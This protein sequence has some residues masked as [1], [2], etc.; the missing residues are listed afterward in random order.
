MADYAVWE[1]A[2]DRLRERCGHDLDFST[3]LVLLSRSFLEQPLKGQEKKSRKAFQV[4]YH[5]CSECAKAWMQT[6]D[7]IEGMPRSLVESREI[8]AE[9]HVLDEGDSPVNR[10]PP[11]PGGS[12][13]P[14]GPGGA[15]SPVVP[16]EERDIPN[17]PGIRRHVLNRD[18]HVCARPGCGNRGTLFAH[19]V[20][21]RS[22]GGRTVPEN[23]VCVCK[24]CHELIHEGLLRVEGRSPD[25]LE[26]FDGKGK[27]IDE[28]MNTPGDGKKL[29]RKEYKGCDPR[30]AIHSGVRKTHSGALKSSRK[31]P[32]YTA[33]TQ[34][35]T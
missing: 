31:R 5:R 8:H 21:W 1:T 10:N 22:L 27:P 32:P 7:G 17:S 20:T 25:G 2:F 6:S 9:V 12:S 3:A 24:T 29:F 4:I 13:S 18:G 28:R 16:K 11:D 19:H 15:P 33:L 35:R 34:S 26:W 14:P 30:G 23:E